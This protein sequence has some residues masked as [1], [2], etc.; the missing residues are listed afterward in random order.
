M[1]NLFGGKRPVGDNDLV[2]TPQQFKM[3]IRAQ[4]FRFPRVIS[5]FF[6]VLLII[7]R[8][9]GIREIIRTILEKIIRTTDSTVIMRPLVINQPVSR[10]TAV[11]K[12][13]HG[14]GTPSIDRIV[15]CTVTQ[16]AQCR[17][18]VRQTGIYIRN[19]HRHTGEIAK[20]KLRG[21]ILGFINLQ[22]IACRQR[23]NQ[24]A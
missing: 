8:P 14:V 20:Q 4:H 18:L 21:M 24:T 17:Q 13:L 6:Q 10:P 12:S 22:I 5:Q 19:P 3:K 9:L 23:S 1:I 7:G 16:S 2:V 15:R 11:I